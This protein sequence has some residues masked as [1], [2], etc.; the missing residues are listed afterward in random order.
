MIHAIFLFLV[1]IPTSS[2][3]IT[4]SLAACQQIDTTKVIEN[5]RKQYLEINS[6]LDTYQKATKD[7]LGESSEGG[8]ADVYYD[9]DSMK[10][11]VITHYGA[12]GKVTAEYYIQETKVFFIF[13]KRTV[14]DKPIYEK[15]SKVSAVEEDRFYFYE[16]KMIRWIDSS[17]NIVNPATEIFQLKEKELLNAS[18]LKF[19]D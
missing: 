15:G 1:T 4:S 11:M 13:I 14:Y 5:I 7:I 6:R 19:D 17:K 10:K 2:F 8:Q 9:G 12:I 16:D 18:L 3:G